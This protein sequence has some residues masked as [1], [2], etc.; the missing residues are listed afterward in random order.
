MIYDL[1]CNDSFIY[2]LNRFVNEI[3]FAHKLIDTLNESI[4]IEKYNIMFI[5]NRINEKNQRLFFDN[6][7]YVSFIDVILMFVTRFKKQKF[8]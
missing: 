6:I 1:N 8:I 5:I 7:V 4:M 3:T 2:N